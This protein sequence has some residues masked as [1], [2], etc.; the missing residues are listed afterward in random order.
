V[1]H[2][3]NLVPL[4]VLAAA[5]R[6]GGVFGLFG[7]AVVIWLA[8]GLI[9]KKP[10]TVEQMVGR[11]RDEAERKQAN[12]PPPPSPADYKAAGVDM[13]TC[14]KC[15]KPLKSMGYFFG[16]DNVPA[17]YCPSCWSKATDP[18]KDDQFN[19]WFDNR[20]TTLYDRRRL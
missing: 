7:G 11:L 2:I 17:V 6:L 20:L 4:L 9:W 8:R 14:T 3:W 13:K 5:A 15:G 16:L 10:E 12:S 18:N 19:D 1:R